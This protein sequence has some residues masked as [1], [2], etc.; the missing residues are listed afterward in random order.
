MAKGED[1]TYFYN[2]KGKLI[3]SFHC[4]P[5]HR[6]KADRF[7]IVTW[8]DLRSVPEIEEIQFSGSTE[9]HRVP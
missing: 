3:V 7:K 4:T 9:A 8:K 1:C 6:P 2:R 5:V